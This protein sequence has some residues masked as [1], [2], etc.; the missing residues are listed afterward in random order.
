[1]SCLEILLICLISTSFN[2]VMVLNVM[3]ISAQFMTLVLSSAEIDFNLGV[4][5]A[6]GILVLL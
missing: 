4:I 5:L 3:A 6:S 1:M 2:Y